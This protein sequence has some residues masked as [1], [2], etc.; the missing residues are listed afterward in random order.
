L[1]DLLSMEKI[2]NNELKQL[3]VWLNVNRLALNISKTNF[4]IFH[5]FNKP[6]QHNVTLKIN[7]KAIM[8]KDHIKY[9]GVIIDS[10]LN[11]KHHILNVSKK[12]SR[13]IGVM[14]KL[15]EYINSKMLLNIYYSLIYSHIVYGIQVWGSACDTELN[16]IL[17]LQ[18]KS[19]RMMTKNDYYP[20]VPGPLITTNPIFKELGIL[21]VDDVF[22]LHVTKFIFSCLLRITPSIFHDWF[23]LN[24]TVHN[25]NTVSNTNINKEN[26]FDIGDVVHT[27]ILHTKGSKLV[28]YGGKLLH[29]A[30]P[31]LWNSLPSHIRDAQSVFSLKHLLKKFLIEQ[32]V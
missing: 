18:K 21:K 1:S 6:L 25:H 27:N 3:N 22:K 29:V 11:W 17:V 20:Q 30:G 2:I 14:Y 23:T 12:I 4:V 28:N 26:Y 9:L 15:R 16:K 19:V 8:Q 10:H 7:R 32:Y 13:S 24:H 5:P 31:I